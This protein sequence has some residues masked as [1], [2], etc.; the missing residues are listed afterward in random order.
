MKQGIHPVYQEVVYKDVS[1]GYAFLTRST[2]L[3]KET[4]EW[5][6]GKTYPV[7]KVEISSASHPF[8]TGKEKFIDTQGR[9][10][11]FNRKYG[12]AKVSE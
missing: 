2:A 5:E 1:S 3:P 9:I 10:E 8:F 11:R 4:I 6:D 7:L 12:K